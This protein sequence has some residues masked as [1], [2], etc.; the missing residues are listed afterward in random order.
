MIAPKPKVNKI[1]YGRESLEIH[2]QYSISL[3]LWQWHRML[4][5]LR[6]LLGLFPEC[7]WKERERKREK[8]RERKEERERKRERGRERER[9]IKN[10]LYMFTSII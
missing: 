9:E 4:Y 1:Y 2:W 3:S 10:K 6:A 7:V 5:G 8:G